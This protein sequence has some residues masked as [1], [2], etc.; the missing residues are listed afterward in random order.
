MSNNSL[1]VDDTNPFQYVFCGEEISFFECLKDTISGAVFFGLFGLIIGW[2]LRMPVFLIG[3]CVQGH[4]VLAWSDVWYRCS[5][6]V[7]I[8]AILMGASL[9]AVLGVL[10]GFQEPNKS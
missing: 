7:V 4:V 8:A 6:Y 10:I 5:V 1:F 3:V 2:V 9:G